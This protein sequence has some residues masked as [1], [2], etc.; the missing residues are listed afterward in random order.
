[1]GDRFKLLCV[2]AHPADETLGC[3]GLIVWTPFPEWS[4]TTRPDTRADWQTVR[5]AVQ[6]HRSQLPT[7]PDMDQLSDE[8]HR[9]LWG[10]ATLYGCTASSTVGVVW[11]SIC[12]PGCVELSRFAQESPCSS[13]FSSSV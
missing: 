9:M 2:L 11:S 12:S 4:I 13:E 3:G 1:M 8:Q 10:R 7:L 6:C 5:R